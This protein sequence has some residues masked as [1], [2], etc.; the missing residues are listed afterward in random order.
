MSGIGA[1]VTVTALTALATTVMLELTVKP[2]LEARSE[3]VKEGLR[4]RYRLAQQ[5]AVSLA[6]C[7]RLEAAQ[8]TSNRATKTTQETLNGRTVTNAHFGSIVTRFKLR[9]GV[10]LP[11][12]MALP[13]RS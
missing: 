8:L 7:D 3:S 5:A 1:A 13:K 6:A 4:V 12:S 2:W 11:S 9:R 10:G